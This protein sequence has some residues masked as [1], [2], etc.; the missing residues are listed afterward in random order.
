MVTEDLDLVST[1]ELLKALSRRFDACVVVATSKRNDKVSRKTL[2]YGG[3]DVPVL[4]L[5]EF[6]AGEVV[7]ARN[8]K[9]GA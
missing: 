6:A 1:D 4:Q 3:G 2:F 8:Q 7:K 9:P 5:L